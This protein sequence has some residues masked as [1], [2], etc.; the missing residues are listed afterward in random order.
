MRSLTIDLF[1][2]LG[3]SQTESFLSD[4]DG[5]ANGAGAYTTYY[6]QYLDPHLRDIKNC[7]IK[8]TITNNT[9]GDMVIT[10]AEGTT[11]GSLILQNNWDNRA[12]LTYKSFKI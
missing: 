9:T 2:S 3:A 8:R 4:V 5:T 10:Y 12:S 6:Y 11:V 1:N 7:V